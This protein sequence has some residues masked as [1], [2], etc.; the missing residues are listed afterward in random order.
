MYLE[1]IL[2]ETRDEERETRKK[3]VSNEWR[4]LNSQIII[5][6]NY[7]FSELCNGEEGKVLSNKVLAIKSN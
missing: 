4:L 5:S 1:L 3:T 2:K 6:N 7:S